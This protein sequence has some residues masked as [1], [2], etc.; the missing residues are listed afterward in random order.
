MDALIA[1][2]A[3]IRDVLPATVARYRSAS[4]LTGSLLQQIEADVLK[5]L[6]L[7]GQHSERV[8]DLVRTTPRSNYGE[9]DDLA[10]K[11]CCAGSIV[12]QAIEQAWRL[13]EDEKKSALPF[14]ERSSSDS[15]AN[16]NRSARHA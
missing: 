1:L 4:V 10:I 8:L 11:G 6:A 12:Q 9:N 3:A 14:I 5:Q 13:A 7:T 16:E 2:D 15:A